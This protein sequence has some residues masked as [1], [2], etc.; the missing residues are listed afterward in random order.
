MK[1]SRFW[2]GALAAGLVL[3]P[4]ASLLAAPDAAPDVASPHF[5]TWGYDATGRDLTVPPG[6][7]F[8][9]Y[10]NGAWY[11]RTDIP[12]DRVRFGNF[13]RL[14]VLSE[15]RTRLIMQQAAAGRSTDPDAQR[16]GAAWTAFMDE[17]RVDALDAAPLQPD[18][19]AI[20]A[21]QTREDVA[22]DMGQ[23][24]YGMQSAIFSLGI[25][26][27]AKDPNQY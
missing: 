4:H 16:I 23:A 5:G 27:D 2:L 25:D 19:A 14:N 10:A 26:A 18:L 24:P 7:D 3:V 22:R 6:K 17:A 13:D 1:A 8:F 12:S 11:A 9:D 21:E 15:N 20:R